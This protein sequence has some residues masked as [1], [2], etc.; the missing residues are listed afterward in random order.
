MR[1]HYNHSS[2]NDLIITGVV[3]LRPRSDDLVEV[4]PLVPEGTWDWFCLDNVQYHGKTLTILWDRTGRKFG[5]G[6]GLRVF[7]DGKEIASTPALRRMSGR[8]R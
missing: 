2:Y 7:A 1:D 4:S 6:R 8:L 5:K 3:G